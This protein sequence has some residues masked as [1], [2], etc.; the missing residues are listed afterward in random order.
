VTP[1]Y[2]HFKLSRPWHPR[3]IV[4]NIEWHVVLH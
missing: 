4:A 3:Q 1:T 2:D